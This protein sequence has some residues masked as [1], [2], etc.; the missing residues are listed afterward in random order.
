MPEQLTT[1]QLA[2]EATP[3]PKTKRCAGEIITREEFARMWGFRTRCRKENGDSE[4]LTVEQVAQLFNF[5]RD[6]AVRM[7]TNEPGVIH[8]SRKSRLRRK[9]TSL[10]IPRGVVERV[11]Q[12]LTRPAK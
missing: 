4:F 5:S 2:D 3:K 10:R 7:F 11:K 1:D 6:T 8:I 9:Y 12:R